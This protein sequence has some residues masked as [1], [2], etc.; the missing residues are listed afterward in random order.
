MTRISI[1]CAIAAL[2]VAGCG[3][4]SDNKSSSASTTTTTSTSSG[5]AAAGD[6]SLTAVKEGLKFDKSSL[7]AKAGKVTITMTNDSPLSH[8]VAIKGSGVD[9]TGDAVGQGQTSTVSAD[10]KPGTYTFFCSVDG[11]EAAGMKGNLT[12]K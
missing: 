2:A 3:G 12:V 9:Q 11:H 8:D 1:F 10:L 6:L 5:G 7:N 4:G